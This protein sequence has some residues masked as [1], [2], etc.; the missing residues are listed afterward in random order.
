MSMT[1]LRPKLQLIGEILTSRDFKKMD[2]LQELT[3]F[4][5]EELLEQSNIK[6]ADTPEGVMFFRAHKPGQ[7]GLANSKIKSLI[8]FLDVYGKIRIDPITQEVRLEWELS[9]NAV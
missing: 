6:F 2:S 7:S 9:P 1:I 3:Q 5:C 4:E 8:Y